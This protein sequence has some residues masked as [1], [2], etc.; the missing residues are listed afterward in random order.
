VHTIFP[1]VNL[2]S[3]GGQGIIVAEK[4]P[5]HIA[6][7]TAIEQMQARPGLMDMFKVVNLDPSNIGTRLILSSDDTNRL[8]ARFTNTSDFVISTDD[9][10]FLAYSTPKGNAL[11]AG[12]SMDQITQTLRQYSSQIP[13]HE[14]RAI[15]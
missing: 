1:V 7:E 12:K 10:M 11:D 13:T 5:D 3:F 14:F 6:L 4:T 8:V 2:Y 9:N 15:P